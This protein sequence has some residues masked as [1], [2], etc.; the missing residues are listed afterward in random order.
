VARRQCPCGDW[1]RLLWEGVRGGGPS[2]RRGV[3]DSG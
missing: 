1:A 2:C 3:R